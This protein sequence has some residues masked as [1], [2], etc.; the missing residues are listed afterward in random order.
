[1]EQLLAV[2]LCSASHNFNFTTRLYNIFV[3]RSGSPLNVFYRQLATLII[4]QTN[5][6]P[7]GLELKSNVI[8]QRIKMNNT[9]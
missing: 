8:W 6:N 1:M 4:M 7:V 2:V 9:K 3:K 5:G